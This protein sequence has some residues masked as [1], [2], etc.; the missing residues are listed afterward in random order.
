MNTGLIVDGKQPQF[1]DLQGGRLKMK[2][3]CGEKSAAR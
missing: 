1:A 3:G 2:A